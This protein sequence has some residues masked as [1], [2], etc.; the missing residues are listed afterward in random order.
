MARNYRRRKDV[1]AV[2]LRRTLK[3]GDLV[4]MKQKIPGKLQARCT[5]PYTF[6][7][8]AGPTS[9][10]AELLDTRGLV[11]VS[12]IANLLPYHAEY[13]TGRSSA[14]PS[15]ENWQV[16]EGPAA[17]WDSDSSDTDKY[18]TGDDED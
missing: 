9:T 3:P 17:M 5:G 18:L 15:Q 1:S 13:P 6:L 4:L 7:K 16:H 8:F 10:G 14:G 11:Q 12:A 2:D